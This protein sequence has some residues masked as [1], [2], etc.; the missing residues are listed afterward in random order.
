MKDKCGLSRITI[1]VLILFGIVM[2]F[3]LGLLGITIIGLFY[4]VVVLLANAAGLK[5]NRYAVLGPTYVVGAAFSFF[6]IVFLFSVLSRSCDLMP[7]WN[8]IYVVNRSSTEQVA[9]L[10]VI[11]DGVKLDYQE[12][13]LAKQ[14]WMTTIRGEFKSRPQPHH[15]ELWVKKENAPAKKY[16]CT[17]QSVSGGCYIGFD[18]LDTGIE[19]GVCVSKDKETEGMSVI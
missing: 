18:Y 19:C 10:A 8:S 12:P 1:I 17:V 14:R 16:S 2:P 5:P 13:K 6:W 7:S 15:I 3:F 4:L 11:V 9:L